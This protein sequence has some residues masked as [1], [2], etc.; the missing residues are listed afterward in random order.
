M[1]GKGLAVGT[2]GEVLVYGSA[3][4]EGGGGLGW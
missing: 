3:A 2:R 4:M 1:G